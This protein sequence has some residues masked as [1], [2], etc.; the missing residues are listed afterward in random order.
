MAQ[1]TGKMIHTRRYWE[2][3]VQHLS[4]GRTEEAG[5]SFKRIA[6]GQRAVAKEMRHLD[7]I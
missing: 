4:L 5:C 3:E 7:L 1:R 6:A 2:P